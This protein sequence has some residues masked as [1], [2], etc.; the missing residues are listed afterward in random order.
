MS[1]LRE[2]N[3]VCHVS[4]RRLPTFH[5]REVLEKSGPSLYVVVLLA[6]KTNANLQM[7]CMNIWI[8]GFVIA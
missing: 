1:K 7:K 5:Q 4:F 2:K 8:T 3:A 6:E